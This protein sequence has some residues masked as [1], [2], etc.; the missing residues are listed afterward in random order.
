MAVISDD[1]EVRFI[2]TATF[3]RS[4]I[5]S[6][7]VIPYNRTFSDPNLFFQLY[8]NQ[9]VDQLEFPNVEVDACKIIM[10]LYARMVLYDGE[11][12]INSADVWFSYEV[13]EFHAQSPRDYL[14]QL[15]NEC[16]ADIARQMAQ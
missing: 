9:I 3:R 7:R 11:M 4:T 15:L 6:I 8:F 1:G 10:G 14:E 16:I 12:E 2:Q 5:K 13:Q